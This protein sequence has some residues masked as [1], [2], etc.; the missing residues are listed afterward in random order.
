MCTDQIVQNRI[1]EVK[2]HQNIHSDS[3]MQ[4]VSTSPRTFKEVSTRQM[5]DISGKQAKLATGSKLPY[6]HYH[7]GAQTK[8]Q[9]SKSAKK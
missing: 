2:A 5:S 8:H 6:Q 3:Y 4:D 1:D 9:T 7:K